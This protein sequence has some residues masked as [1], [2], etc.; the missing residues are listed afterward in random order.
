MIRLLTEDEK[1][2]Y[3]ALLEDCIKQ[4]PET[5]HGNADDILTDILKVMGY[6]EIVALYDKVHKWYS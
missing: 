4:D 3:Y 5:G 2:K 1:I 6:I